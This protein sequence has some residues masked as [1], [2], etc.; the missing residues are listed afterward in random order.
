VELAQRQGRKVR[1]ATDWTVLGEPL[2][3]ESNQWVVREQSRRLHQLADRQLFGLVAEIGAENERAE[4]EQIVFTRYAYAGSQLVEQLQW[5]DVSTDRLVALTPP[6]QPS[7][8]ASFSP[9]ATA[10]AFVQRSGS[11]Q[12]DLYVAHIQVADGRP[13]LEDPRQAATGVIANPVWC[14]DARSV[15]YIGMADD[16]FQVW[17]VDVRRDADGAETFGKPRQITT[18][19]SVDASSRP[20][21]MTAELADQV[22]HW[23][24]TPT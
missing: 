2:R 19:P 4:V 17:S 18:G 15:M 14:P 13:Q 6:D 10:L 21:C 5:L 9:D 8:Q 20:V 22:R 7:R 3:R 24:A 16:Q 11:A 23:L 12:E 1:Q